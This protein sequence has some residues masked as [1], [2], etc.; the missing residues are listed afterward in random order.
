MN[1]SDRAEEQLIDNLFVNCRVPFL[2]RTE[3]INHPNF[4]ISLHVLVKPTLESYLAISCMRMSNMCGRTLTKPMPLRKP[5][6]LKS[7]M[8]LKEQG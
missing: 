5:I 1:S 4:V 6:P 8:S 7:S 2:L 3:N